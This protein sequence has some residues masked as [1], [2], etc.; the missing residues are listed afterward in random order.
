MEWLNYHHLLY[1][2]T[3]ARE[4]SI[5]RASEVLSLAPPT[6]S[7]Q[8]V[9]TLLPGDVLSG[10]IGAMLAQ[11]LSPWEA[12]LTGV[13]AHASAGDLAY[14]QDMYQRVNHSG[15]NRIAVVCPHCE[16]SFEYELESL[17]E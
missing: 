7:A 14:L 17:G 3:V 1:F 16:E 6:I 4:G 9:V 8:C 5:A 13:V 12:A 2:W 15:N 10:V 11:G